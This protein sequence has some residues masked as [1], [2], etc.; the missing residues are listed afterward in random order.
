MTPSRHPF[1]SAATAVSLALLVL[2]LPARATDVDGPAD[3]AKTSLYDNGDAPEGIPAYPGGILGRFPT[4]NPLFT[5]VGSV[6]GPCPP[7]FS[8]PGPSDA[9]GWASHVPFGIPNFWL[10]CYPDP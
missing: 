4:C 10:G 3:C 8:P 1:W 2:T 9:A 7:N 5:P 6:D